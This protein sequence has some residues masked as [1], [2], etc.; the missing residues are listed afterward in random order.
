MVLRAGLEPTTIC[1]EGRC[2]IQLSYR[3]TF[4]MLSCFPHEPIYCLTR[5]SIGTSFPADS[6]TVS[7][8]G[9]NAPRLREPNRIETTRRRTPAYNLLIY[10]AQEI[11]STCFLTKSVF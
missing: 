5:N 7:R 10:H 8:C 3:S 11:K 1:L 6:F 4:Y 2:S 9:R